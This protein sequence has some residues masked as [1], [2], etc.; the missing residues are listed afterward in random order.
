MC[1]LC[2]IVLSHLYNTVLCNHYTVGYLLCN[3]LCSAKTSA[4][5]KTLAQTVV[6][7]PY[8]CQVLPELTG[9]VYYVALGKASVLPDHRAS[10]VDGMGGKQVF[11]EMWP[12]ITRLVDGSV[13]VSLQQIVDAVRLLVDSA[14]LV[15]EGAGAAPVSAALTDEVPPGNIVCVVSGGNIDFSKL[16]TICRGQVPH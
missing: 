16:E 1:N 14:S 2:N 5:M 13:T 8:G 7:Y 12:Y 11:E 10:F 9:S 3:S 15:A 6:R 4:S